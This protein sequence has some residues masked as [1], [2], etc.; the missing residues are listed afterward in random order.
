MSL[1]SEL[2]NYLSFVTILQLLLLIPQRQLII[3][4]EVDGLELEHSSMALDLRI[5]P[6]EVSFQGRQVRDECD[7]VS[8][9]S[10][11]PSDSLSLSLSVS[12]S[13]SLSL[14]VSLSLSLS[15]SL[16]L[17]VSLCLSL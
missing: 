10:V 1:P 17:S 16:C 4:P 7:K 13:L 6:P 2:T 5:V 9:D 15:L 11:P 12:L 14:S 3:S 8:I